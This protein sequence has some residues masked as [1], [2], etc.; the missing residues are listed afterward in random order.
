M[1]YGTDTRVHFIERK[2]E[3]KWPVNVQIQIRH[4]GRDRSK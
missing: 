3:P 4:K 1:N 2:K